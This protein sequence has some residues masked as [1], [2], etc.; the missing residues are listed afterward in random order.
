MICA[1]Y[2]S[3]RNNWHA[4][5][6]H[7]NQD[8]MTI[9]SLNERPNHPPQLEIQARYRP[10]CHLQARAAR[11]RIRKH[12]GECLTAIPGRQIR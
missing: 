8:R 4:C 12:H 10:A 2:V 11:R 7:S 1:S 9:Q 3:K 6:V 5:K